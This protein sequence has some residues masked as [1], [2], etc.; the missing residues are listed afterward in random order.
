MVLLWVLSLLLSLD[1][2]T[3]ESRL[4]GLSTYF[5]VMQSVSKKNRFSVRYDGLDMGMFNLSLQPSLFTSRS[6]HLISYTLLWTSFEN[7]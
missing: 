2:K 3:S 1:D 5:A 6:L 7:F 4:V